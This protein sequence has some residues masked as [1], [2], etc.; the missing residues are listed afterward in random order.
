MSVL[1]RLRF[2]FVRSYRTLWLLEHIYTKVD[3]H[4]KQE[5]M[6]LVGAYQLPP[7]VDKS[8]GEAISMASTGGN[9]P[10]AF[11]GVRCRV[12]VCDF[13]A[14]HGGYYLLTLV[15]HDQAESITEAVTGYEARLARADLPNIPFHSEPL[16]NGHFGREVRRC[17]LAMRDTPGLRRRTTKSLSTLTLAKTGTSEMRTPQCARKRG[18]AV[19]HQQVL[20]HRA[21]DAQKGRKTA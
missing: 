7:C 8:L 14:V 1:G 16:I 2:A 3:V 18:R 9:F 11:R 5:L 21:G 15:F 13:I 12:G 19:Y 17:R 10:F 6:D 4:S 20:S